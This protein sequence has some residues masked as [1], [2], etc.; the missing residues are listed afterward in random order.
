MN[1]PTLPAAR[2]PGSPA[3]FT[4]IELLVVLV[5]IAVVSIA[6]TLAIGGNQGRI[7]QNEAGRMQALLQIACER[8]L[9]TGT[10]IG[11][12]FT[13]GSLRF[14]YLRGEQWLP[15]GD[16]SG[17]ELRPRRLPDGLQVQPFID[18][19][20]V[21]PER[22]PER[23]H[24]ACFASGEAIPLRIELAYAGTDEH[25]RIDVAPDAR[26]ESK[27]EGGAGG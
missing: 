11:L 21:D 2:W 4:L 1:T 23:P 12:R 17:D 18:G 14:G 27:R 7:L 13:P 5:I 3:G 22:D 19:V 25:W 24:W 10:D 8:A 16:H 6:V 15:F 9:V 26:V 20:V